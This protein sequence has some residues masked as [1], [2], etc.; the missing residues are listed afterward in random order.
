M[1]HLMSEEFMIKRMA[2][3]LEGNTSGRDVIY[4]TIFTKWYSSTNIWNLLFGFG[5]A[6]SLEITGGSYAHNDWLELLSNFGL[7]GIIA[8][9][10]SVLCC[11]KKH[12]E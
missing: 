6:G 5:F 1:K 11:G 12:L 7:T 10:S 8:Y 2:S 4:G 9:L 3:I